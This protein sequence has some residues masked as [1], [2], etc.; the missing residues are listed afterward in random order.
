MVRPRVLG[1]CSVE[2]YILRVIAVFGINII[3]CRGDS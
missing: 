3:T 2:E 1:V